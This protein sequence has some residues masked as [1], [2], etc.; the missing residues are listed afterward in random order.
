V[1]GRRP[2]DPGVLYA[3]PLRIMEELGWQPEHS[4]LEEILGSAWRWKQKQLEKSAV[5]ASR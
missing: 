2:G 1:A 4:S 3:S 5:A